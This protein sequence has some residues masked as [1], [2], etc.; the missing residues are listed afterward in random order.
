MLTTFLRCSHTPVYAKQLGSRFASGKLVDFVINPVNGIFEALWIE[1]REGLK[2]LSPRDILTW[3]D[4]EIIIANEQEMLE[5]NDFPR[6]KKILKQEIPI[7]SST[8]FVGHT[9]YGKV[10]DFAFDTISPR[11]L[12][13]RIQRGFWI[14]GEKIVLLAD[15]IIKITEKGIYINEPT[16]KIKNKDEKKLDSKAPSP[17]LGEPTVEK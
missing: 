13:I 10:I 9:R 4:D 15:Q 6:I 7:L 2:L 12:S 8:V 17:Q 3:N 14:F 5:A 1:T 16:V 11:L